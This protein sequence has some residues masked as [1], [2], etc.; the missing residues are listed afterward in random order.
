MHVNFTKI[1]TSFYFA[2]RYMQAEE[3]TVAERL[4]RSTRNR[5]GF[6]RVGS[7]PAGVD[8]FILC[9]DFTVDRWCPQFYSSHL[10]SFKKL[11]F[12]RFI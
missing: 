11:F 10:S 4:R 7:S 3:D 8:I 2:M 12:V 5:L 1:N 9:Q 6:S